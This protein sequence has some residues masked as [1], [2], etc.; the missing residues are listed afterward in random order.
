MLGLWV[1]KVDGGQQ[2]NAGQQDLRRTIDLRMML[3]QR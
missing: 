3:G 2:A 1:M